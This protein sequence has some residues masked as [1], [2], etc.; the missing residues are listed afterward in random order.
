MYENQN[1][2]GPV[3]YHNNSG[4]MPGPNL[5]MNTKHQ[6]SE[7]EAN[8]SAQYLSNQKLMSQSLSQSAKPN[9]GAVGV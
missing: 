1:N 9:A 5:D 6:I 8:L 2:F 3:H 4:G 7:Q